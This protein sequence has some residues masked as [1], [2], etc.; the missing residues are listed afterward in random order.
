MGRLEN[1]S[2][3]LGVSWA[4]LGASWVLV[5]VVFGRLGAHLVPHRW[6]KKGIKH[7]KNQHFAVLECLGAS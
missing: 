3:R 7:M 1:V 5:G 4:V 2:G 6:F